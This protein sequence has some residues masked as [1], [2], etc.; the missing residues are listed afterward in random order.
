MLASKKLGVSTATST[1]VPDPSRCCT[2]IEPGICARQC[3]LQRFGRKVAECE[4]T[5]GIGG[6]EQPL[7][8]LNVGVL[9]PVFRLLVAAALKCD[10]SLKLHAPGKCG[11]GLK[12]YA[13]YAGAGAVVA[14]EYGIS[15]G[16]GVVEL[17]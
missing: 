14:F 7:Y 3:K 13:P 9:A 4:V 5:V 12:A 16:V 1:G 2:S 11:F 15:G 8:R 17:A 10:T 6:A